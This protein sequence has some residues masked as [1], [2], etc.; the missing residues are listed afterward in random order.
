MNLKDYFATGQKQ[1]DL[2]RAINV[3]NV[4]IHQWTKGIRRVPADHCP[5]I[6]RATNGAVRCEELRPHIDWEYLRKTCKRQAA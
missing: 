4:L 6:E 1:T 2:A 5:A 3:K